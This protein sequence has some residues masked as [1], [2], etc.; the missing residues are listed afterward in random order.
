VG[1]NA[2][3][4]IIGLLTYFCLGKKKRKVLI[5]GAGSKI[6]PVYI[7]I[8]KELET[9]GAEYIQFDEPFLALD[10]MKKQKKLTV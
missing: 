9:H 5:N 1:I 2:K 6:L 10:L 7:Q 4:V 8:L 3:P